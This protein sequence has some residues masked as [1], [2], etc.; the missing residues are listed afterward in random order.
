MFPWSG[1][2]SMRGNCHS[3]AT[4][5]T[6]AAREYHV[7][8]GRPANAT[9]VSSSFA[10]SGRA[11]FLPFR[12]S[13]WPRVQ[14]ME[15]ASQSCVSA[16]L[17]EQGCSVGI[18][19]FQSRNAAMRQVPDG[20]RELKTPRIRVPAAPRNSTVRES[21]RELSTARPPRRAVRLKRQQRHQQ[22][23]RSH[24]FCRPIVRPPEV[25]RDSPSKRLQRGKRCN[26]RQRRR[27]SHRAHQFCRPTVRLP[28]A[29]GTVPRNDCS[30]EAVQSKSTA[31]SLA[32][33]VSILPPHRSATGGLQGQSLGTIAAGEAVQ[34]KTTAPT[35]ASVAPILPPHRS[36]TGGLQGQSLETIAAG[37]AVQSKTTAPTIAPVA[38]ILP[39]HRSATGGLQGQSL[40]TIAAGEAVQTKTTAP[41]I[42]RVAPILPP[43][44]SATGGRRD[45]PLER[46][47]RG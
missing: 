19:Q 36:A 6:F 7:R 29:A 2:C 28:E 1:G 31:P 24:Q 37:E 5:I 34:T 9:R 27:Q 3:L 4:N 39:P 10:Q 21:L 22:S 42:A 41:T 15:G 13:S 14:Q 26:R 8:G 40:G 43:H 45:S 25:C 20:V 16:L 33:V 23:H 32:W 30:G 47:Q 35:I 12:P 46:L 38:P 17:E 44:H 11:D 18:C